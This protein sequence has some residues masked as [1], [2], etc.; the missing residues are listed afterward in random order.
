MRVF[1]LPETSHFHQTV[2]FD[3]G[4]YIDVELYQLNFSG[5]SSMKENRLLELWGRPG[6]ECAQLLGGTAPGRMPE[7]RCERQWIRAR[8][9]RAAK[10]ASVL[11]TLQRR[12]LDP[13]TS[14]ASGD[15]IPQDTSIQVVACPGAH[16]EVETVYNSII[17]NMLADADLKLTDIAVLVTD[18]G[19][20][21]PAIESVFERKPQHIPYNLS[22]SSAARD[23]VFAQAVLSMLDMALSDRS[24]T[25]AD[26]FGL[27]LN[28]SFLAAARIDRQEA[29]IWVNWAHQ[30]SVFHSFDE[31]DKYSYPSSS[32]GIQANGLYTWKMGLR[33]LRLGRIMA[34]W[35]KGT[36]DPSAGQYASVVPFEDAESRDS[37]RVGRFSNCI[38]GLCRKLRRLRGSIMPCASWAETLKALVDVFLAVPPDRPEE[39]IVRQA[40]S[41]SL[42]DF[43]AFDRMGASQTGPEGVSLSFVYEFV[44]ASLDA[45]PSRH[46]SYLTGGVTISSLKP[47]RPIPFKI[48]H[49]LGL[50]E[51]RFPGALV[52]STLDLRAPERRMGDISPPEANRYMFL[53]ILMATRQKLY[54]TY[55]C[56]DLQRD[57]ELFPCSV[58]NQL[59]AYLEDEV[60]EDKSFQIHQM[61][62]KGASLRYLVPRE[63]TPGGESCDTLVDFSASNRL[64]CLVDAL[65]RGK[66][67]LGKEHLKTVCDMERSLDLKALPPDSPTRTETVVESI[68]S[69]ELA[70]F[71][72]N[73]LDAVV[74]RHLGIYDREEED[75]WLVEDE[76]FYLAFPA[77]Y[78]ILLETLQQRVLRSRDSRPATV[79]KAV[80]E[81]LDCFERC[82]AARWLRGQAP[83]GA[84]CER[85]KVTFRNRLE[86]MLASGEGLEEYL[87]SRQTRE[88]FRNITI[89]E[90][91]SEAPS[92]VRFP[93]LQFEAGVGGG[94]TVCPK[95]KVTLHGVLPFAWLDAETGGCETLVFA[96]LSGKPRDNSPSRH[97]LA[98]F[99]FYMAARASTPSN[100]AAK[101]F[102]DGA[103]II[104]VL[105]SDGLASWRCTI[106]TEEARQYMAALAQDY[107][108]PDAFDL[109]P[110]KAI[111]N[112]K[113]SSGEGP[114]RPFESDEPA[115]QDDR[116]E[117]RQA[118]RDLLD[119]SVEELWNPMP[120]L[121]LIVREPPAGRAEGSDEALAAWIPE[122]ALD[123]VQRRF[124]PLFALM[125]QEAAKGGKRER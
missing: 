47:M 124:R 73:P 75:L 88:F 71:L 4:R 25:R 121:K 55:D 30:L 116:A 81:T 34:P 82:Y 90:G 13:Q 114:I 42:E 41:R 108:D 3:L 79:E 62:L 35:S 49:I 7:R 86:E 115:S 52:R 113:A 85:D 83:D 26:V 32:T 33:R 96:P 72:E 57:Q 59:R 37:A 111:L 28:P 46:G 106:S 36:E 98:P 78:E 48:V 95:S 100:A 5:D 60:I 31:N 76:P 91:L 122:D 61:P 110:F 39:D 50:G 15:R 103:F 89:G 19:V 63:K 77:D 112:K 12:I 105:Y 92:D 20:Y 23:S 51:G 120:I 84:Y 44:R 40:L 45:I 97:V 68:S 29:L 94:A 101:W 8:H 104:S 2:L 99:I 74:R 54:L 16:R 18:M 80:E 64:L 38:E 10:P 43:S 117:Y 17:A 69:R 109:L 125:L 56:R 65:N 66:L 27:V 87:A 67:K 93:P 70:L 11:Q 58:V 53:E 119:E 22:D 102:G 6:R 21:K 107:L 1:G 123:K 9:D 118:L 24:F 14:G